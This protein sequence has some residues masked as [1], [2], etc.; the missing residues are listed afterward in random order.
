ML[1]LGKLEH[2]QSLELSG[3]MTLVFSKWL[4]LEENLKELSNSVG[5]R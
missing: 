4:A 5:V 1:E 3:R 2:I